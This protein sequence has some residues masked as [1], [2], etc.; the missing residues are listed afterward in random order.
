MI[1]KNRLLGAIVA[2]FVAALGCAT[3]QQSTTNDGGGPQGDGG[4]PLPDGATGP[5][6]A[7][8]ACDATV[9]DSDGDGVPDG[10]D[11]C[12]GTPAKAVV[13]K[14]GCAD[15]Q[16][17]PK[18]NPNFPPYNMTWTPTGDLGRA[19]G[20][21]WTYTNIDRGDLFHIY[22]IVCDDPNFPCGLSLDGPIDAPGEKWTYSA[23][24]SD[25]PNGKLVFTNT[26]GILLADST[27]TPLTG[28]LTVTIVDGSNVPIPFEDVST[29][30]VKPIDGQ[31]GAEIKG[32]AYKVTAL[33]EVEDNTQVWTPYLD[34]YDAAAT[35]DTGDAGGNVYVSFGASF[36]DK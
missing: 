14:D 9:C 12:A 23:T 7:P 28:R 22:W 8:V 5:D 35:A 4:G 18:L 32:T 30:G 11:K 2:I 19:G 6:G 1:L 17:T 33:A 29:L 24:D 25:L 36:Y 31:Y 13:N 15:S 10:S 20:L 3:G 34:Y 16:L 26:T 27:T 21:T